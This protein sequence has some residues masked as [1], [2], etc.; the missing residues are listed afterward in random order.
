MK[1]A[2]V[3]EKR[4]IRYSQNWLSATKFAETRRK[5]AVRPSNGSLYHYAGN[6]PVKYTDP[7]GRDITNNT[8]EYVLGKLEDP[9]VIGKDENGRDI[10]L[11]FLIIEPGETI[12]GH[13]DGAIMKNGIIV[14]VSAE[15]A[16]NENVSFTI[17]DNEKGEVDFSDYSSF[18]INKKNDDLKGLL[19]LLPL[20]KKYDYSGKYQDQNQKDAPLN[21]WW[22]SAVSPQ[23][24]NTP[25]N[26]NK[27]N[28]ESA[29]QQALRSEV[30][31]KWGDE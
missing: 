16:W 20:G 1:K 31:K 15:S 10:E 9:I 8:K 19:N 13:F 4:Y 17:T 26:W 21:G 14:K 12:K 25:E 6:T 18:C 27:E 5:N 22:N 23:E 3:L 28:Q 7:D 11:T 2:L 30:Q 24:C 29:K